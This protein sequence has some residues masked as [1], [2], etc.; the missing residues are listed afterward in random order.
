DGARVRYRQIPLNER[1]RNGTTTF[2]EK[3]KFE[4][5]LAWVTNPINA[6]MALITL[7]GMFTS[8]RREALAAIPRTQFENFLSFIPET[9]DRSVLKR[10]QEFTIMNSGYDFD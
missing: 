10:I 6:L 8:D 9:D 2:E 1:I 3:I 5:S 7:N 4:R